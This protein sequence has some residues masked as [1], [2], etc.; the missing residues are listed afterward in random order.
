MTESIYFV[1]LFLASMSLDVLNTNWTNAV[2]NENACKA[3]LCTGIYYIISTTL[4]IACCNSQWAIL[5]AALGHAAGTYI[6]VK[7]NV[8]L[9]R[10]ER[11][12]AFE[13]PATG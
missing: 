5:P 12:E 11:K 4:I 6:A 7:W 2:V 13:A 8:C 1:L 10:V 3:A 9:V